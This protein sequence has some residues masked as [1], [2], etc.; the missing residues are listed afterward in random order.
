M[1]TTIELWFNNELFRFVAEGTKRF[2]AQQ[3]KMSLPI[4]G[5]RL[6]LP[7]SIF[8]LDK[9]ENKNYPHRFQVILPQWSLDDV[10]LLRWILGFKGGVKV[11]KPKSLVNKLKQIGEDIVNVYRY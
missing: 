2:P 4:T 10:E 3:M 9:T 5:K 7:K 6:T 1:C 11:I 8:C